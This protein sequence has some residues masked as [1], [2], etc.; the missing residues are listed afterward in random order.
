M[1]EANIT[2]AQSNRLYKTMKNLHD[3]FL[4]NNMAYWVTGG[5]LLGAIRHRGLIPWDDD[6]DVCI[7]RKDVPTLRSLIPWFEKQG[8]IIEEGT[9]CDEDGEEMECTKKKDS[10]TWFLE[11]KSPDSLGVDIFVMDRLGPLITYADPYWR[12][13]SNG[14]RT[15]YFLYK[16]VFPLIG[17]PFGNFWVLTP[18]NPV[19]HLNTCY[20]TDWTSMC[21][22]LFD[23]REGKWID[24][25]KRRMG[26]EQYRTPTAP[27]STCDL[28]P[29][30]LK[31]CIKS[32]TKNCNLDD[33]DEK[34]IKMLA[35]LYNIK[36]YRSRTITYLKKHLR[37]SLVQ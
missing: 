24:S 21:Q 17:Q 6:G 1:T 20:G 2:K 29:P 4:K 16:D 14:G 32:T 35:K 7:M 11:H 15:C 22:R 26:A 37:K 13:A 30:K 10:C 36:N 12:T 8:Y 3:V 28:N 18:Y 34:E 27:S 9:V 33:L 19:E 23:H 25:K 5:S 31:K